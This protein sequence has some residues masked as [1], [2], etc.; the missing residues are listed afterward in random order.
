MCIRHE[1]NGYLEIS[2]NIFWFDS[3]QNTDVGNKLHRWVTDIDNAYGNVIRISAICRDWPYSRARAP[4]DCQLTR[5]DPVL[6]IILGL[7]GIS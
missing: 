4:A 2:H 6:L 7:G 3:F 5:V 1:S